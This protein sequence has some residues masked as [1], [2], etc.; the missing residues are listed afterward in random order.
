[1]VYQGAHE[2]CHD[3]EFCAAYWVHMQ[4]CS[5]VAEVS[6]PAARTPSSGH[7][8][9]RVVDSSCVFMLYGKTCA[10]LANPDACCV[11]AVA[12]YRR[13][14]SPA[15]KSFAEVYGRSRS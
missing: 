8:F 5:P 6:V 10:L 9:A 14:V 3:V 4:L 13:I 11:A 2:S 15:Q 1:M 7:G 12:D